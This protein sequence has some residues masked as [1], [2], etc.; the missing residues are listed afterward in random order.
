MFVADESAAQWS[1]DTFSLSVG[2]WFQ[3][4]GLLMQDMLLD[5]FP[6]TVRLD[7]GRPG[8]LKTVEIGSLGHFMDYPWT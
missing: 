7:S 8:L 1:F 3:A 2:S 4:G 5:A 6:D